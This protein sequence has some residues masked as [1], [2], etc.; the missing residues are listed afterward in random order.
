MAFLGQSILL[1]MYFRLWTYLIRSLNAL[2]W[3]KSY[4]RKLANCIVQIY[5]YLPIFG[6]ST[7]HTPCQLAT[8][9]NHASP[10]PKYHLI[11]V[12]KTLFCKIETWV[13]RY[14]QPLLCARYQILKCK[15]KR[16]MFRDFFRVLVNTVS[17][18]YAGHHC[19]RKHIYREMLVHTLS[20]LILSSLRSGASWWISYVAGLVVQR[21]LPV[22]QLPCWVPYKWIINS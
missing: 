17:G 21:I 11:V 14:A 7:K 10:L 13:N 2:V 3:I 9:P 22:L 15:Y 5:F 19:T 16:E 18:K 12:N 1:I 8:Y 4:K 20:G 6:P